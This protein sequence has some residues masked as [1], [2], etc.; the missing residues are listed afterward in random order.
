MR[1]FGWIGGREIAKN[2]DLRGCGWRLRETPGLPQGFVRMA[3]ADY[4]ILVD[5]RT[6]TAGARRCLNGRQA[7]RLRA[8]TL[9]LGVSDGAERARLLSKGYGDAVPADLS[10][11]E[12]QARAQRVAG[13]AG[14]LHRWRRLGGLRLDLVSREAFAGQRSL[15]LH[16]REFSLLWRLMEVPGLPVEKRDLLRDVWHLAYVPETNSV[17]VHASRLR[18][19]LAAAGLVGW[20]E[21]TPGGGYRLVQGKGGEGLRVA[22]AAS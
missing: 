20:V 8:W 12:V 6:L 9:V 16:P 4:P 11:A 5:H 2:A 3:Q 19:K 7:A 14:A 1:W 15:G 22:G 17:A 21:T 13:N 10:L 18:S